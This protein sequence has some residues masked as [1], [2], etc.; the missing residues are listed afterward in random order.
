M[1]IVNGVVGSVTAPRDF[2]V[3]PTVDRRG[4]TVELGG[5]R[6]QDEARRGAVHHPRGDAG[7]ERPAPLLGNYNQQ[8]QKIPVVAPSGVRIVNAGAAAGTAGVTV[9]PPTEAG[10]QAFLGTS[11]PSPVWDEIRTI[12]ASSVVRS[13]STLRGPARVTLHARHAA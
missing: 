12:S 1:D 2:P 11:S 3:E 10:W 8:S 9:L 5:H 13:A 7:R 6:V 4:R